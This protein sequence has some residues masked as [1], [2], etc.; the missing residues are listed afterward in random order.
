MRFYDDWL[1]RELP[2]DDK[3]S[4]Q[5]DDNSDEQFDSYDRARDLT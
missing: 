1:L 3:E 4:E 2:D 5:D